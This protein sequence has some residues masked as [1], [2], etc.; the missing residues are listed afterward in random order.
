MTKPDEN[1]G[2]MSAFTQA[3]GRYIKLLIED[4][5]LSIAEKLTRMLAAVALCALLTIVGTV[6]L[7][8][9]SVAAGIALAGVIDPLWSF[10]IVAGFYILLL[11]VIVTCR[12]ALLVNP[13]SRFITRLV[14]PAPQKERSN[15]QSAPVS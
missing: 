1:K 5:R 15:D 13:I 4:T 11:I 8:F 2:T 3:A 7:V 9:I 12:T 10:V 6:A 14:L